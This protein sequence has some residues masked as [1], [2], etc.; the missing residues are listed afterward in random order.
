MWIT[1]PFDLDSGFQCRGMPVRFLA[2]RRIASDLPRCR[3]FDSGVQLRLFDRTTTLLR[4]EMPVTSHDRDCLVIAEAV[5]HEGPNV[6]S[7]RIAGEDRQKTPFL[8]AVSC[9]AMSTI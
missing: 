6:I 7:M 2:N 5:F 8:V 4:A 1:T 3:N 9:E